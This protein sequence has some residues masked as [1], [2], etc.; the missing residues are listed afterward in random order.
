MNKADGWSKCSGYEGLTLCILHVMWK[1]T[2]V[3][4]IKSA[5]CG[6]F[7]LHLQLVSI[8]SDENYMA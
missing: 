7:F 4:A 6:I 5:H 1:E 8:G 3:Y 2:N